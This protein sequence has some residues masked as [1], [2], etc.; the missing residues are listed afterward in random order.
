MIHPFLLLV[1]NLYFIGII[2]RLRDLYIKIPGMRNL[3]KQTQ[4]E[5]N[6][7][8]SSGYNKLQFNFTISDDPKF[9]SLA[10]YLNPICNKAVTNNSNLLLKISKEIIYLA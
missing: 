10:N 4:K 9:F 7:H 6:S 1:H 2:P 5:I 3:Y 8:K